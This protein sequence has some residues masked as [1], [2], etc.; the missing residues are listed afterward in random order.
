MHVQKRSLK[1]AS[2][3][4]RQNVPTAFDSMLSI[5]QPQQ[6]RVSK[7]CLQLTLPVFLQNTQM[8][9]TI[10]NQAG[11]TN[12]YTVDNKSTAAAAAVNHEQ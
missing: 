9:P 7:G 8:V 12:R 2:L 4:L 6:H 3:P 1:H 10:N 5:Q 11:G